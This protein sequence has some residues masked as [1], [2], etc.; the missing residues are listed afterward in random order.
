MSSMRTYRFAT[1][2]QWKHQ[3]LMYLSFRKTTESLVSSTTI[4]LK[5]QP[6]TLKLVL[7][8]ICS[9]C[10]KTYAKFK[11]K[12]G[13]CLDSHQRRQ[14]TIEDE[15]DLLQFAIQQSLLDVGTENDRVDIWEALKSEKPTSR[16]LSSQWLNEEEQMQRYA[17]NLCT[18]KLCCAL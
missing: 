5:F 8:V 11:F 6:I 14:L 2:S 17:I 10:F 15:D 18:V 12:T 7:K 16:S 1:F 4:A 3:F 9:I 13:L